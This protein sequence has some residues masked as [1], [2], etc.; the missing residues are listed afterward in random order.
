M[1]KVKACIS[2][3]QAYMINNK[4]KNNDRKMEFMMLKYSFNKSGFS[5]LSLADGDDETS[6]SSTAKNVF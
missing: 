4:Q 3:V 1:N 2:D 6:P 5:K